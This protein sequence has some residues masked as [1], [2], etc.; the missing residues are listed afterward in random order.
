MELLGPSQD[1]I[2]NMQKKEMIG[3]WKVSK[4]ADPKSDFSNGLYRA[5]LVDTSKF[6]RKDGIKDARLAEHN[7]VINSLQLDSFLSKRFKRRFEMATEQ[8]AFSLIIQ[9]MSDTPAPQ[10]DVVFKNK[11]QL[12]KERERLMKLKQNE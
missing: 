7:E 10:K 1:I 9:S 6:I 12:Q 2:D 8:E 3:F 11:K 5:K 4:T